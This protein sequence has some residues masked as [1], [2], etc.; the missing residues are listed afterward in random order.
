MLKVHSEPPKPELKPAGSVILALGFRPF[1]LSAALSALIL[2]LIWLGAWSGAYPLPTYYG[3]IGWHSHEMLFGYTFAIIA[4]FLLTAVRNWTGITPP[5]GTPLGLLFLLWLA[6]RVA[7]FLSDIIPAGLIA[8]IDLAFIPAVALAIQPAL[9][10]GQQKVNRIFVP[11]LLVMAV[12]N[13]Y[14]HLQ[15]LGVT[16]SAI[17][18]TDAMLYLVA[19]LITLL[20]GRVIPF[21]TEAVIPG[22]HSKRNS[23]V[24][25]ATVISL[26]GL[27]TVQFIYPTAWL[28]GA[29]AFV[30]AVT[31]ITRVVGWYSRKI[32]QIPILWVLF[33]GMSWLIIGFTLTGLAY[34]GYTGFNLAKHAITVGGIGALT[35]GMMARVAL[36]HTGREIQSHPLING[37]FVLLNIA[38]LCRVFGPMLLPQ[39]YTLWIHISGGLWVVSFLLF[40]ALYI[41]ILTK[42]RIDGKAG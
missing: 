5:T 26:G 1:F 32:W 13:L 11:L 7:P 10:K 36:G 39:Q 17:R 35:Y 28:S 12:A 8:A 33:S 15:A 29:L 6:G 25:L 42:P 30:V 21:F 24:E 27:I 20:G 4:G 3:T 40:S 19:F 34:L 23:Q 16:D 14:V 41:P 37:C 9:W 2:M 38:A 18:G 22:H 31:Q